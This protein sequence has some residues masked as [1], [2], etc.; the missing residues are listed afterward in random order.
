M[1][2][3]QSS[4]TCRLHQ[5]RTINNLSLS[6]NIWQTQHANSE[7]ELGAS[8]FCQKQ[9]AL[10]LNSS[11]ILEWSVREEGTDMSVYYL[12]LH[13]LHDTLQTNLICLHFFAVKSYIQ[14]VS[15]LLA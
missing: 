15:R 6:L 5:L 9:S 12:S 1:L 14:N 7:G 13:S 10:C 2:L 8:G 4:L 3:Y 11:V